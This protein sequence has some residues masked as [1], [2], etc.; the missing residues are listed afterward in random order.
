MKVKLQQ[1]ED[2]QKPKTGN[3]K[4]RTGKLYNYTKYCGLS[5]STDSAY[6]MDAWNSIIQLLYSG[7]DDEVKSYFIHN[8]SKSKVHRA[9]GSI[10]EEMNQCLDDFLNSI[11]NQTTSP[12]S[13]RTHS[14]QRP[15]ASDD[16]ELIEIKI[17]SDNNVITLIESLFKQQHSESNDFLAKQLNLCVEYSANCN[18]C[19]QNISYENTE[20]ACELNFD[21]DIDN[22]P[23]F[24]DR[25]ITLSGLLEKAKFQTVRVLIYYILTIL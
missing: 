16:M 8:Q 12:Q 25:V 4:M 6:Q 21:E 20:W 13:L 3:K 5:S 23:I 17:A 11:K 9:I 15:Y 10:F 22:D 14:L 18:N 2:F 7:T 19:Y 1:Q 24:E